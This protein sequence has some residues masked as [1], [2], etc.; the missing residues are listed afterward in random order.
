MDVK[1]WPVNDHVTK[2]LTYRGRLVI[3]DHEAVLQCVSRQRG[4]GSYVAVVAGRQ[5]L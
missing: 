3:T 2:L 5:E 4:Q 1:E